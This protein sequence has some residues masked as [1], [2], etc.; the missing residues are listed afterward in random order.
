MIMAQGQAPCGTDEMRQQM[1]A[2]NPDLLRQ[3]AE[4][5]HG[6]QA[7]LQ[8]KAGHRDAD[9][10]TVYVI[11]IVFHVLYD[12][13]AG[14]DEH[15]ISDAQVMQEVNNL[16]INYA[17]LNADTAQIID[18]FKPAAS[19]INVRFELATKDPFGNC[20][21]GIDRITTLRST[22]AQNYSKLDPWF[23][24]RYANVWVVHGL[25]QDIPG[26]ELLGYSQLPPDVQDSY[27]ALIDG[28]IMLWDQ[29]GNG[30]TLT[31][32][33][34]H[35]LN[36][37]HTWGNT[38][39]PGIACG[40]DGVDDTPMTKG[41][42]GN[43]DVYDFTCSSTVMN[44]TY[45]F[46]SV[47]PTSGTT[48]PTAVPSVLFQD[49]LPG[50]TLS[51]VTA[52]GVSSDPTAS[53]MFSFSQW[54][55]GA[56][57]GDTAYSQLTG[58]LS[59]STYY[60]VSVDP[61][62]ARAMSLTGLTFAAGRTAT[63][64]RTFA[65]RSSVDNYSS[66]LAASVV[67]MGTA[68]SVQGSNT[69][70]FNADTSGT[71]TGCTI[72]LPVPP[73]THLS[74]PVTFRIYAWNAEDADG[75]FAVDSLTLKGTYGNIEN[76]QNY[77]EYSGCN[78]MFTAG[79][80]DRM[81]ATLNSD[82]SGRSDLWQEQ[83][84]SFTG[85]DGHEQACG[86]E[87][88]FYTMTPFVCTGVPIQFKDNSKR[89]TPT[90]WAWS[91]EGGTPATS[92]DENPTVSF[93]DPG[94]HTITLTCGNDHGSSS[95]TKEHEVQIG[96]GWSQVDGLLNEP[97]NDLNAFQNWPNLNYESNA[98]YW[99]WNGSVGHY[100]PG[101]AKLNASETYYLVQDDFPP[102]NFSDR[103]ILLTP[104]LDLSHVS[105]IQFNF[106][107]A[108]AT[109][110]STSADITESL[111]IF[112][113][114][115]CGK[116]WLLRKTLS[117]PELVTAGIASAG[118]TPISS[119]WR[120]VTVA[121]PPTLKTNH[122]RIKFEYN[123]GLFSNDIFIDDVNIGGVV[124]ID[125][126][127]QSGSLILMPNPATDHLTVDLDLAASTGGTLSFLDMTGRVIHR[128][129][130]DAGEHQLEF[131]LA[132]MGIT[133]GVYLVELQHAHGRRVERLVVR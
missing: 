59:T 95:I 110:T 24:D 46:A 127:A 97:F 52:T 82:I 69:F 133:S 55:T 11:P 7:Y 88:D 79:Q 42:F 30:T 74:T 56:T 9:D 132:K 12:P 67:P 91:F 128:Q 113:S 38:N 25:V 116:N 78:Y 103:D 61:D 62:F 19:K 129:T 108:Y 80:R 75:S 87:A 122:V 125:E 64:P 37:Q 114:T 41:H 15:N 34:G 51:S 49:T 4:A 16:N 39:S 89:A 70:F 112:S 66:N 93:A 119:D 131:D 48:D 92:T 120:Q 94:A 111:R 32:E 26:G 57:Q 71:A 65:V 18:A 90:S 105:G 68:L 96:P 115:D 83:N 102:N 81:R 28:V 106:W 35:F 53:G 14:N 47:T 77:M 27:G 121:L 17:K 10:T 3:E 1:I 43:C 104:T 23:R 124:G 29:V 130:V 100:A 13:T 36:L 60:Q 99:G 101:C 107:Y 50:L 84:H 126:L 21:N 58:T 54:G 109:R 45:T 117:G 22:N 31:H 44:A 5:E 8:A 2:R 76:V 33:L 123:S 73:Y 40:D 118:Y 98:T 85:T 6:L 63:G 86:P 72:T 20:T